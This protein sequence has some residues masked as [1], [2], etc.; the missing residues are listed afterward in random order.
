MA[1]EEAGLAKFGMFHLRKLETGTCIRMSMQ[2]FYLMM[3]PKKKIK[4]NHN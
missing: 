2:L 4:K 3:L 1:P